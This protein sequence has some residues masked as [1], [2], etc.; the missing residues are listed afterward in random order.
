M[1]CHATFMINKEKRIGASILKCVACSSIGLGLACISYKDHMNT[2]LECMGRN[3]LFIMNLKNP[4]LPVL[5]GSGIALDIFHPLRLIINIVT[6]SYI[7]VVPLLY[8]N[9]FRFRAKQDNKI[10]GTV[11]NMQN[12]TELTH[13]NIGA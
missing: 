10:Q 7:L 2:Y 8:C 13:R 1:V 9:I 12:L 6:F 3:E 5:R 11:I 4:F